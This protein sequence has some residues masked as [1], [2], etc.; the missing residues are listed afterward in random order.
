MKTKVFISIFFLIFVCSCKT[1][2]VVIPVLTN[3]QMQ[4]D[5]SFLI[6]AIKE[7]EPNIAIREQVTR[8]PIMAEIDSLAV[9]AKD[10]K[11][12]ENFY[13]LAQ[14]I[15]LLCQ[16]QHENLQGFYP[17][18]IEDSNHYISQEAIKISEL[19]ETKYDWY[20]P[21]GCLA[22]SKYID[23]K[24]YFFVDIYRRDNDKQYSLLIPSGSQLLA[25]NNIPINEYVNEY[26]RKIDNS[27]RWDNVRKNITHIV[28]RTQQ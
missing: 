9:I 12:F 13:Y 2:D 4:E 24:Y 5:I 27:I 16:D 26:G 11:T 19:C 10:L 18:G 17:Q 28:F 25:I 3:E 20:N 23:G 15:L 14:R 6:R 21:Q 1:L 7:I 22:S 8:T